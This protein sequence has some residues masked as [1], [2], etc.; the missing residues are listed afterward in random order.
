M[1]FRTFETTHGTISAVHRTGDTQY[2]FI[3][4]LGGDKG[5]F[6]PAFEHPEVV[7]K[8]LLGIDL[9]GFGESSRLNDSTS[10]T[11]KVQAEITI[12]S[13]FTTHT[14]RFKVTVEELLA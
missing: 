5:I 12:G 11:F 14:G 6:S 9:L 3:H 2:L 13:T 7:G 4:G 8:G 10:Y 1:D